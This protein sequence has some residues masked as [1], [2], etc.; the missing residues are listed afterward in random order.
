[1]YTALEQDPETKTFIERIQEL[2]ASTPAAPSLS[3]PS[4]C[5]GEAP[6]HVSED[7]TRGTGSAPA[8]L[9]GTYRWV[10]TQEDADEV[11]DPETNYPHIA[12][13]TLEDGHLEGGCFGSQGGTYAVD[14]DRITFNSFQYDPDVTASF[15]QDD[16]GNLHLKPVLPIDPGTA[17]ECFYKPW[18]KIG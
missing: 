12:T 17:F 6:E 5:T 4:D 18:T 16:Q 15:T 7:A 11:G 1:V 10:L 2:K 3:I 13:I 8:F 9:N 14:G